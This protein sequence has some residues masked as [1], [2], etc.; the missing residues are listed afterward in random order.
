MGKYIVLYFFSIHGK[1]KENRMQGDKKKLVLS[2]RF[3]L[4][5][6]RKMH[7]NSQYTIGDSTVSRIAVHLL[8]K[9]IITLTGQLQLEVLSYHPVC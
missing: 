4:L 8:L 3:S 5:S 9:R 7:G 2:D 6:I 1:K